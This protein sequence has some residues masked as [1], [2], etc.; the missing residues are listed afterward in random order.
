[1]KKEF[2]LEQSKESA[3]Q[4]R[5]TKSKNSSTNARDASKKA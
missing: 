3:Q 1:M 4:R 2:Q 5:K